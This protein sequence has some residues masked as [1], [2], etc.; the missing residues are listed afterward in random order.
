MYFRLAVVL[1][2]MATGTRPFRGNSVGVIFD[3]ILNCAPV[4]PAA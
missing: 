3:A 1:Y 4:A 2:E